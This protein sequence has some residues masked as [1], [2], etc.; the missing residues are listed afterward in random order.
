MNG[1]RW[2]LLACFFVAGVGCD[3]A[4]M[5][6]KPPYFAASTDVVD[7]GE[8]EVG[9]SE[10]RT[11]FL[12]NKGDLS[13]ALMP[14]SGALLDGVFSLVG[15]QE[16]VEPGASVSV[17][18]FFNPQSPG[19]VEDEITFPN[20]SANLPEFKLQ[21]KGTGLK[22]DPCRGAAC[23][24]PPARYCKSSSGSVGY[25]P[26]GVCAAGECEYTQLEE[27]HC[28]NGCDPNTGFCRGIPARA[29]FATSR[30]RRRA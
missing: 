6:S 24:T 1:L 30:R 25:D 3:D 5:L 19:L 8:V 4:R 26:V 29:C 14:P 18:V 10:T 23:N 20:D 16:I 2:S 12:I 9:D 11:V 15:M 21:V 22:R 7:F 28:E 13:M 27:Q 17:R